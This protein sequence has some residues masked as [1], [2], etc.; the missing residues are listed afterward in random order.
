LGY[1]FQIEIFVQNWKSIYKAVV[2]IFGNASFVGLLMLHS[3]LDDELHDP[4]RR[5]G[6]GVDV[7]DVERLMP[8]L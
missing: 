6:G 7:G 8:I 1:V 5:E 3:Y 4:V 2:V